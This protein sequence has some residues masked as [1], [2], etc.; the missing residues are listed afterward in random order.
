VLA[1]LDAGRDEALADQGVDARVGIDLGFQP[2]ASPSHRG[3]G[4]VEERG[5]ARPRG[6]G[7]RG[8]DVRL[9]VDHRSILLNGAPAIAAGGS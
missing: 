9:P 6:L 2:S 4:E 3:G 7:E 8:V 1:H 5:A